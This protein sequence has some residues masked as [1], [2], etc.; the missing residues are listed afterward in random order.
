MYYSSSYH[1]SIRVRRDPR[2]P[3]A[4]FL[5]NLPNPSPLPSI[6]E[7][8]LPTKKLTKRT[9]PPPP[10]P[11]PS[12]SDPPTLQKPSTI[13]LSALAMYDD[14]TRYSNSNNLVDF[15][16]VNKIIS[17]VKNFDE[18]RK[19][20][21]D[22]LDTIHERDETIVKL[23][24]EIHR[25][26]IHCESMKKALAR[27]SKAKEEFQKECNVMRNKMA[28]LR[29]MVADQQRQ[30]NDAEHRTSND[31][32][33]SRYIDNTDQSSIGDDQTDTDTGSLLFDKSDDGLESTQIKSTESNHRFEPIIEVNDEMENESSESKPLFKPK[34]TVKAIRSASVISE[35][36]QHRQRPQPMPRTV[37][38]VRSQTTKLEADRLDSRPHRF[39]EK[40]AFKTLPC[41]V[42]SVAIGFYSS[43]STCSECRAIVHINCRGR[44]ACP[45]L[46]YMAPNTSIRKMISLPG[47]K[48][49]SGGK[50]L[51]IGDF[52]PDLTRPCVPAILIHCCNEIDRRIRQAMEDFTTT[53]TTVSVQDFESPVVGVY[54]ISATDQDVRQLRNR[55]LRAEHGLPNLDRIESIHTICGVVKMFLRNLEDSLVS[56]IMWHNFVRASSQINETIP[57][58]LAMDDVNDDH[59]KRDSGV[60]D[61]ISDHTR[62][63]GDGMAT[64]T[65]MNKNRRLLVLKKVI[66]ELPLP[67]RDS[68]AFLIRHLNYVADCERVTFMKR[69]ALATIFAPTIVG[70]SKFCP[71]SPADLQ[72]EIPKQIMVMTALFEI[73]D[74]FWQQLLTENDF[75][76]QSSFQENGRTTNRLVKNMSSTIDQ[77]VEQSQQQQQQQSKLVKKSETFKQP[78]QQQQQQQP[79]KSATIKRHRSFV[80]NIRKT[81]Y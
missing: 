29:S 24:E 6:V 56:R 32:I 48:V 4:F 11:P 2:Q 8:P 63:D 3:V 30:Q 64:N 40:K 41:T 43:Y 75:S 57:K 14:M 66:C 53:N 19:K 33:A 1:S 79:V 34:L 60:D 52:V 78:S 28:L 73:D 37:N 58:Q 36:Q 47:D 9:T 55:I 22:A 71:Q 26:N 16:E 35:N 74:K 44:L 69:S 61:N 46:P 15:N 21:A 65:M 27:E 7:M 70:N 51:I 72:R 17:L 68:L 59:D 23:Q 10:L 81:F 76:I 67:H 25:L 38:L 45:C 80:E 18:C 62:S 77:C 49:L 12:L 50:F 31:C 13:K 39:M 42:C 54:R 20:W 5:S